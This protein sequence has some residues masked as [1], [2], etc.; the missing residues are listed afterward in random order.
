[1]ALIL[2][3]PDAQ[4]TWIS[5]PLPRILSG[6]TRKPQ[7]SYTHQEPPARNTYPGSFG[8]N[9]DGEPDLFDRD[10]LDAFLSP[11]D[12]FKTQHGAP[13]SVNEFGVNRWAPNAAG[14]MRDEMELFEGRG[15]N[16]AFWVWDPNWVPWYENVNGMNYRFGPDPDNVTPVEN[17]LLAVILDFWT[18]SQ[19][20]GR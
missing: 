6:E 14:F 2:L 10:W 8:L 17:D 15:M 7:D 11:I 3:Q 9:W 4:V 5:R 20:E 19:P 1:M 18:G 12:E 13:V 16:H